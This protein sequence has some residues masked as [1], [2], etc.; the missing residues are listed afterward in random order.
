VSYNNTNNNG[1]LSS[2]KENLFFPP[3]IRRLLTRCSLQCCL[4]YCCCFLLFFKKIYNISTLI[5]CR[6][7]FNC[8]F[9]YFSFEKFFFFFNFIRKYFDV[10]SSTFR[11]IVESLLELLLF[12]L[13]PHHLCLC[14]SISF[15]IDTKTINSL[16]KFLTNKL[17]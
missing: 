14:V 4:Y 1:S 9:L 10:F 2:E 17:Q 16:S 3:L 7:F 5:I 8:K 12:S 6:Q 13:S 11:M 15:S